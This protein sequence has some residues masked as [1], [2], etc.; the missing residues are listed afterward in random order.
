MIDQCTKCLFPV[1]DCTCLA[2]QQE[3]IEWMR[4]RGLVPTLLNTARMNDMMDV[5]QAAGS[6][7]VGPQIREPNEE[8]AE[9]IFENTDFVDDDEELSDDDLKSIDE[10]NH[11]FAWARA[12]NVSPYMY[13]PDVSINPMFETWKRCGSPTAESRVTTQE[14]YAMHQLSNAADAINGVIGQLRCMAG[15]IPKDQM[16]NVQGSVH[17]WML[18]LAV[19]LVTKMKRIRND[20]E[21]FVGSTKRYNELSTM[22][23]T[24]PIS[25]MQTFQK[26]F[27]ADVDGE[28]V[29]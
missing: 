20:T 14:A 1:H 23:I 25:F 24:T 3:F 18:A 6:P 15:R 2:V 13:G 7:K 29:E 26:G 11:F 5:W 10:K 8:Q 4:S 12:N 28:P 27:V 9:A 19:G 22:F 17:E 21:T 16:D